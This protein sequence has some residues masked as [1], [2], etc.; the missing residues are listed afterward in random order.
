[1]FSGRSFSY[2]LDVTRKKLQA[3]LKFINNKGPSRENILK[4]L[5]MKFVSRRNVLVSILWLLVKI[6]TSWGLKALLVGIELS[7][8]TQWCHS[9]PHLSAL[10]FRLL[11]LLWQTPSITLWHHQPWGQNTGPASRR[12]YRLG[13]STLGISRISVGHYRHS[14]IILSLLFSG[15]SFPS[16]WISQKPLQPPR[17]R[18]TWRR[19]PN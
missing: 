14:W 6:F 4:N 5:H 16:P 11:C 8:T 2:S 15:T 10:V 17:L 7:V 19:W 12:R 3:E 18:R 13:M 1:M 9:L